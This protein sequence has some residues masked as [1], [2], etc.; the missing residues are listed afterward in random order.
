M[1]PQE[2]QACDPGSSRLSIEGELTVERAV[3]L[4]EALVVRLSEQARLEIDLSKVTELD[5]AGVQLLLL[6]KQTAEA[7]G[8]ELLLV[9]HSPAVREVF[10]LLSLANHFDAPR[11]PPSASE[12]PQ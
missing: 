3:E 9:E 12:S 4:K 2:P 6:A 8:K 11:T 1:T 10:A 5:T 7:L